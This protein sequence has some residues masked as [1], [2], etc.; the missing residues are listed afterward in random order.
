MTLVENMTD[1]WR[2]V[3]YPKGP[4]AED[5]KWI[6]G[7]ANTTVIPANAK[8][9]EA[10]V[11]LKTFLWRQ[12][13]VSV[14]DLLATHVAD[15]QSADLFLR[16]NYEWSGD[17]VLLFENYLETFKQVVDLIIAGK[18]SASAGMA[19]LKPVIQAKLDELFNQ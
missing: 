3:P 19:E 7:G 2:I 15:Q 18:K 4:R 16:S 11:A 9:P 17:V 13:D 5:N 6:V 8:D 14:N 1:E 12:E 10:L